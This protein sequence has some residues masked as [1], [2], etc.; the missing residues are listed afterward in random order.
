VSS[1]SIWR[2]KSSCSTY[3]REHRRHGYALLVFVPP[4]PDA[5]VPWGGPP[6]WNNTVVIF[7]SAANSG[8]DA[9][10][11]DRRE[12]LALLAAQNVMRRYPIDPERVYVG[13]FSGGSRVA[14][15]IALGYP[16][17]FHGA[18]L[19]AGSDRSAMRRLH[20]LRRSNSG[21]FGTRPDWS[22]SRSARTAPISTR[23]A[24]VGCPCAIG[25]FSISTPGDARV[26]HEVGGFAWPSTAR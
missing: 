9:S 26:G 16:D 11:L 1:R 17:V 22:I 21:R 19:N 8:N 24:A 5:R 4:W 15:R 25:A 12:P 3:P 10:I 20:Y 13:G 23:T 6:S 14:L 18:L 2:M 7:V